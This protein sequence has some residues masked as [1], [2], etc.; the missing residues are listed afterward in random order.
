ML[1]ALAVCE[2]E[3][4]TYLHSFSFYL[5]AVFFLGVSGY[6]FWSNLCYFSLLS[7]QAATNPAAQSNSF[8]LME[9]VFAPFLANV[10]VLLLLLVPI[11]TMR[12][13]AEE[14]KMGT[15]ELLVTY[16]VSGGQILAGKF[17]SVLFLTVVLILPTLAYYPFAR[18]VNAD[19]EFHTLA[20]GYL[21]LLLVASAFTALGI[22][23]SSLTDHQAVSA[24]IGFAILLFFWIAGWMAD[25]TSPVLG[26]FFRALS[27][28][29]HFRDFTR[30]VIDTKDIAYF[31]LFIGFFLFATIC[32][33]E[34][35]T[36]KR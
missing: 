22:F 34:I 35:R 20:S 16:P 5:T 26:R 23:I 1:K 3:I 30:G 12:S 15:L 7:Y 25:W 10:S 21:G 17:L 11:L 13:F 19:F 6:F 29:E 14:R 9:H 2:R 8:N 31:V 27:L 32:S 33:L 24:G 36:W 4:N 18:Q 28:V